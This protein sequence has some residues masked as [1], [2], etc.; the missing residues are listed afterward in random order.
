MR[1]CGLCMEQ[2]PW[3][4]GL[5]TLTVEVQVSADGLTVALPVGFQAPVRGGHDLLQALDP[6]TDIALLALAAPLVL[7]HKGRVAIV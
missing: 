3:P 4:A 7:Q 1:E 2:H 6:I 5:S